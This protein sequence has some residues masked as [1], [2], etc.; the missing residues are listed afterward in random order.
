MLF[1][2]YPF[3][4]AFLP[5][6]VAGFFLVARWH[7]RAAAGWLVIASL[8]FYGWWSP[9]YIVMLLG[10]AVF[11]FTAGAALARSRSRAL[12]ALGIAGN[13]LLLGYYKYANFFLGTLNQVAGTHFP[14]LAIVLPIGISF[15]TFTQIAYLV[16]AHRGLARDY[17]L[18]HYL[19]FVTYFPHL[20]AGPLLHHGQVMPQFD[21]PGTYRPQAANINL[22][23][24]LF[25]TGLFKKVVLADRFALIATPVFDA[26]ANGVPP[27]AASGWIGAIAYA[28]QLYFDFSGYCDMAL[29]LSWLFNVRLPLNFFS[30]YRA[31]DMIDFWRRW[32]MTLSAF[33]RDYLYIPLGGN[34][35]GRVRRY[36]NLVVTML[37]GGLWHGAS[38]TFV[39]WGAMHGAYLCVN[40]A[41]RAFRRRT[42][43]PPLPAVVG[44]TITLVCVIVAWVPFRARDL[45]SAGVILRGM[46]GMNGIG[47]DAWKS[48]LFPPVVLPTSAPDL[49]E[50]GWLMLG[51]AI[52]F[53]LPNIYQLAQRATLAPQVD[54][55][56]AP[57]AVRWLAFAT[58][59]LFFLALR[60]MSPSAP[61]PFLYFQF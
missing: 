5:I 34:R 15:Y 8:V 30:P 55:P 54:P 7:R 45:H 46:A 18:V 6:V 24:M 13:L 11:N 35:H 14:A 37:L 50:G 27:T 44:V 12:L 22:G 28:L 17:D 41:W 60:A 58:G 25:A 52:V 59:V 49:S 42:V 2:S 33:L 32:H 39:A 23:L 16:D 47:W 3:A 43:S 29:G 19:L 20:V 61:S 53:L 1:N 36:I 31:R 48:R 51:L 57:R 21:D 9:A 38:W 10:S 56:R 26:A 4:L 40:H